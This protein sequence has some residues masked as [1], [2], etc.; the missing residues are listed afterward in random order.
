ML[1]PGI[2]SGVACVTLLFLQYTS[3]GLGVALWGMSMSFALA[4]RSHVRLREKLVERDTRLAAALGS[5]GFLDAETGLAT[6]AR[7]RVDWLSELARFQRRGERFSLAIF[8]VREAGAGS[9]DPVTLLTVSGAEIGALARSED[10]VYRV[11]AR[12]IGVLLAGSDYPGAIAFVLRVKERLS[13]LT[14]A[15]GRVLPL[16]VEADI[17]DWREGLERFPEERI[18]AE[19]IPNFGPRIFSRWMRQKPAPAD[20]EGEFRQAA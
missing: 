18:T 13:L 8:G 7:L 15:D 6:I 16:Q 12:R 14:L 5:G 10:T 9:L 4:W 3:I 17:V 1:A 19:N 20:I 11:G 2:A